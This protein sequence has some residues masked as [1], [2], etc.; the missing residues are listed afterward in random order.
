MH[1]ICD[2]QVKHAFIGKN[3]DFDSTRAEPVAKYSTRFWI[4]L[5]CFHLL[6]TLGLNLETS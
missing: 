5:K 2:K 6:Y 1:E 4:V 3:K